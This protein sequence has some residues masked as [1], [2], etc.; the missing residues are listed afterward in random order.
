MI[1]AFAI[2]TL[3]ERFALVNAGL[4]ATRDHYISTTF[5]AI[6]LFVYTIKSD[7]HNKGLAVI[8]RKYSTWLY[9]IHPIFI[10]VFSIVVGKLGFKLIYRHVAPIVVYCATLVFLIVIQKVKIAMKSK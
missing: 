7:W 3:A 10:T 2:T 1:I 8:G 9:I 5:L 4:N 6:C